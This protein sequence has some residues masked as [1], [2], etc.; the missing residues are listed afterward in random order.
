MAWRSTPISRSSGS[1]RR[2]NSR[3]ATAR[4]HGR[5]IQRM[6]P[7]NAWVNAGQGARGATAR[8]PGEAQTVFDMRITFKDYLSDG[9]TDFRMLGILVLAMQTSRPCPICKEHLKVMQ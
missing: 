9:T 5:T 8:M 2:D 4:R 6:T 7:V 1:P 3:I